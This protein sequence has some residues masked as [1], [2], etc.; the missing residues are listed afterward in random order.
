MSLTQVLFLSAARDFSPRVSFQGRLSYVC[1]Y[2]PVCI[3]ICVHVKDSVGHVRVCWINETLK[4]PAH[5]VGWVAR[6]LQLAFPGESN[7][8]FP[9]EKSQWNIGLQAS[10]N[11]TLLMCKKIKK[12]IWSMPFY[13]SVQVQ[14]CQWDR[15][16]HHD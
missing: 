10:Y 11:L 6:L 13:F 7:L 9:W 12:Q 8:N 2:A 15:Y 4:H 3:N 1:P 5:T 14:L 16:S